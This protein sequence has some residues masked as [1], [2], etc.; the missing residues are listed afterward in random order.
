MVHQPNYFDL[1]PRQSIKAA[2]ACGRTRSPYNGQD[3]GRE[4]TCSHTFLC[5]ACPG[6]SAYKMMS[7]VFSVY[8]LPI[9][10]PLRQWLH[11]HTERQILFLNQVSKKKQKLFLSFS[12]MGHRPC[13]LNCCCEFCHH[14]MPPRF[15]SI[16]L[17]NWGYLTKTKQL[18]KSLMLMDRLKSWFSLW[19]RQLLP[20]QPI[21]KWNIEAKL[22]AN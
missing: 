16:F 3:K 1:E 10:N 19:V 20:S 13:N 14:V 17:G 7:P 6:S 4:P 11:I 15:N 18:P 2:G 9:A 8:L 22:L 12:C 5:C 21:E